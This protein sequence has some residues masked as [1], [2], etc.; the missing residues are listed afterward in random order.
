M[1]L[2]DASPGGRIWALPVKSGAEY[3]WGWRTSFFELGNP[4]GLTDMVSPKSEVP[5]RALVTCLSKGMAGERDRWGFFYESPLG[6][7]KKEEYIHLVMLVRNFSNP[8]RLFQKN[9]SL[10]EYQGGVPL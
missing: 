9:S 4:P 7:F 5:H 6:S 8:S 1:S 3:G 2:A 10:N